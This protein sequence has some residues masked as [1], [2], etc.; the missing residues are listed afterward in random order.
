MHY[1]TSPAT[2]DFL[3]QFSSS[4]FTISKQALQYKTALG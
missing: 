3:I 1:A 2:I 4:I